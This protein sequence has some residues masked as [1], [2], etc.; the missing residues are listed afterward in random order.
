MFGDPVRVY[1]LLMY[2]LGEGISCMYGSQSI[3]LVCNG[4]P[5]FEETFKRDNQ[6]GWAM[7]L[8]MVL[9]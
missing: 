6:R 8:S 1:K 2:I 4:V 5:K 3:S 7:G 9:Q